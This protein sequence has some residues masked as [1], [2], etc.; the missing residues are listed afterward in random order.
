MKRL[1]F[2][3]KTNRA[4]LVLCMALLST[5]LLTTCVKNTDGIVQ[6]TTY[7]VTNISANVAKSGGEV[8]Y[9]GHILIGN[10]GV[11]YGTDYL[12]TVSDNVT[13]DKIGDGSFTSNLTD[14][15]PGTTY[16]VRAYANT[17]SGVQYG[18]QE[19]FTTTYTNYGEWLYYG[20]GEHQSSWGLTNGGS[21]SWG[22]MFPSSNLSWYK[23]TY[24]SRISFYAGTSG[25]YTY[26]IYRG[27]NKEPS[28]LLYSSDTYVSSA[29]K[30]TYDI[31]PTI[32]LDTSENLWVIVNTTHNSGTYPAGCTSGIDEAN[33]R[34]RNT[35]S[36]WTTD[37]TNGWSDVCWD[38][39]VYLTM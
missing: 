17:S 36:S 14:L 5:M 11:C 15:L 39:Q 37:L 32:S 29:G 18:N 4:L 20:D 3:L 6:V 10:C 31:Y 23:G 7:P 22:V 27:G 25:S 16:Y 21:L 28:K 19:S 35:G 24:I 8:T 26:S 13:M 34:W 2:P 1:Q 33:A 30:Y 9:Y 12:P 38:I